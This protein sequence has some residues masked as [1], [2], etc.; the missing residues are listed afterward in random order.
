M[1]RKQ[2]RCER[3]KVVGIVILASSNGNI[4]RVTGPL[5]GNP[6]STGGF[7]SQRPVTQSFDIFFDPRLNKRSSKQSRG[8]WFE[9][10]PR[11]LWRHNVRTYEA[12]ASDAHPS[13][14]QPS[15]VHRVPHLCTLLRTEQRDLG[16]LQ[17]CGIF[18]VW[19]KDGTMR[20]RYSRT[21]HNISYWLHKTNM[22]FFIP[23]HYYMS[24]SPW[25]CQCLCYNRFVGLKAWM[26]EH[27]YRFSRCRL[28]VVGGL[29]QEHAGLQLEVYTCC[30]LR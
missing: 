5:W 1:L 21:Y 20:D 28:V 23:M 26:P 10:P 3:V 18:S 15:L 14:A 7:P 17:V 6:P 29:M 9:T 12:D 24:V 22:L 4:I 27:H 30:V 11:S 16:L 25:S 13:P 8:R 19:E 2:V